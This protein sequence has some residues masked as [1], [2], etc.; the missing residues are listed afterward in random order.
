VVA[1]DRERGTVTI[2]AGM[3]YAELGAA[4]HAE[5]FSLHNTASLPHITVAGAVATATHGSGD[6]NGCLATAVSGIELVTA[7]GSLV[8]LTR[9]RDGARFKGAVV[10]LGSLGVVV[11]LTLDVAP[12]YEVQ[13]VVYEGLPVARLDQAF[14]EVMASGYSVSLFTDWRSD[15]VNQVWVKRRVTDASMPAAA[16]E[17]FG[18]RL[19]SAKLRILRNTPTDRYTEQM[20]IPGPWHERLPHFTPTGLAAEGAEIQS[21]Y[22]VPR[23]HAPAAFRA[24]D[25][26]RDQIGALMGASEVRSIAADDL[27]MSMFYQR[28]AVAFHFTWLPDWERVRALLPVIEERLAP[29]APRP[30]WGKTFTITPARLRELYPKLSEFRA[31]VQEFD[32]AGKFRNAFLDEFV[33]GEE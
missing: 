19:A 16:P 25:G 21:E 11:R 6:R 4:L 9:E 22:F 28:D 2:E 24:L 3:R 23:E 30:H 32:P 29:F 5:G 31:L 27:W 12:T 7:D 1:L 18:S 14:A 10:A 33:L 17:L 20:D 26:I 13:Q 15:H 8:M